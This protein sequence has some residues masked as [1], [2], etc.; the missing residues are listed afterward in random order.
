MRRRRPTQAF[1]GESNDQSVCH[2][3]SPEPK[4]LTGFP[5]QKDMAE[6][7]LHLFARAVGASS[8]I[9]RQRQRATAGIWATRYRKQVFHAP[10][11]CGGVH[12]AGTV[13]EEWEPGFPGRPIGRIK[14]G[15]VLFGATR[16]G[17]PLVNVNCGFTAGPD[18]PG[19]G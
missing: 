13:E 7:T 6:R 11:R 4:K 16:G 9:R 14:S 1:N 10:V 12:I 18:P 2:S 8:S 3:S 17:L 5:A 15:V 19:A